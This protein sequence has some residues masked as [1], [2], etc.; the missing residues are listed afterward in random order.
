MKLKAP[1]V[2]SI[3]AP[4]EEEKEV[5]EANVADDDED[6]AGQ[7]RGLKKQVAAAPSSSIIDRSKGIKKEPAGVKKITDIWDEEDKLKR[8]PQKMKWRRAR[9]SWRYK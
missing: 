1:A 7:L 4:K 8:N 6:S 3:E 2:T 5:V 9:A